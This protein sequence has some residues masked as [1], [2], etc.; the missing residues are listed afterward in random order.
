MHAGS[1]W[2]QIQEKLGNVKMS[3]CQSWFGADRSKNRGRVILRFRLPD[4]AGIRDSEWRAFL[5]VSGLAERKNTL[6]NNCEMRLMPKSGLASLISTIFRLTGA[7]RLS[8]LPPPFYVSASVDG[9]WAQQIPMINNK[10]LLPFFYRHP[11]YHLPPGL[12]S[13]EAENNMRYLCHLVWLF[14]HPARTLND[15][16]PFITYVAVQFFPT[17]SLIFFSRG[18]ISYSLFV[19]KVV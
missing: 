8:G 7:G 15:L 1:L 14:Q 2:H 17:S 5:T 13:V 12:Q 4:G 18:D 10:I 11:A 3:V 19:C 6:P 16:C 9:P